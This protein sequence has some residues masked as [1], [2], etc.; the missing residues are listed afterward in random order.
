MVELEVALTQIESWL[1]LVVRFQI[2][3]RLR[4]AFLQMLELKDDLAKTVRRN[5]VAP[6]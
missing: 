6:A 3:I 1:R 2:C 5:D 4:Q